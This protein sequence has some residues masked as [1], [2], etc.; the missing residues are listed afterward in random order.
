[1]I[2]ILIAPQINN[3]NENRKSR[4]TETNVLNEIIDKRQ[5]T[6]ACSSKYVRLSAEGKH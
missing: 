5:I 6:K 3:W 2:G 4:K 1:M